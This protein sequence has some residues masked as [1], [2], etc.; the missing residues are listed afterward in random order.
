MVSVKKRRRSAITVKRQVAGEGRTN[1]ANCACEHRLLQARDPR[2]YRHLGGESNATKSRIL[3]GVGLGPGAPQWTDVFSA[4]AASRVAWARNPW[5]APRL[6]V[7]SQR[8]PPS[9]SARRLVVDKRQAGLGPAERVRART[10][11]IDQTSVE[12]ASLRLTVAR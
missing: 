8:E 10:D 12:P 9:K 4:E 3:R 5:F 7:V 2:R 1:V 6:G 11:G